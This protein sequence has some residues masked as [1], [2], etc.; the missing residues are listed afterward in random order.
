MEWDCCVVSQY[1]IVSAEP[2]EDH[3]RFLLG[4]KETD[5]LAKD[6]CGIAEGEES[7]CCC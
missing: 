3:I 2:E 1:P 4:T 7:S 5:C 6:K